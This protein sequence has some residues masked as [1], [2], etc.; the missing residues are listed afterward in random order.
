MRWKINTS[1]VYNDDD[2][3]DIDNAI[4]QIT[5]MYMTNKYHC[6]NFLHC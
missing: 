2:D 1:P 5:T 3:D 6:A 4:Q